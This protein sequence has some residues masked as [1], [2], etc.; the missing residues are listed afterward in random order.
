[1]E[2]INRRVLE[3]LTQTGLSKSEFAKQLGVS[4]SVIS[5]VSSGRNKVGLDLVQKMIASY[6][7][8]SANWLLSGIGSMHSTD[9]NEAFRAVEVELEAL[10]ADYFKVMGDMKILK[11]RFDALDALFN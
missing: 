10:K 5:H 4:P 2:A 11:R 8:L 6:P 7:N 9:N 3:F 1:M